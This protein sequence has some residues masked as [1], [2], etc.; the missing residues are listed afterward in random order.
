MRTAEQ[1]YSV[2]DEI[3]G[4]HDNGS[5]NHSRD[6]LDLSDRE[7]AVHLASVFVELLIDIRSLLVE[8]KT[9]G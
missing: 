2:I 8:I 3:T 7:A 5:A 1:L 9:K 6:V 4:S